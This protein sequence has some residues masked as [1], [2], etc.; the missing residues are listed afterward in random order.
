MSDHADP[1][2]PGPLAPP[3]SAIQVASQKVAAIIEAA[4]TAAADLRAQTEA[5][6][7]DRIA[8]ADRAGALRVEAAEA[9]AAEIVAAAH[10]EAKGLVA[11]ARRLRGEA[12]AHKLIAFQEADEAATRT[13]QTAAA[14]G[15][16]AR[17]RAREDARVIVR[18]ARDAAAQVLREG[19]E[20]S[21]NLRDLGASLQRNA[22]RLLGDVKLA[23]SAL[24]ADLDQAAGPGT[25]SAAG[26]FVRDARQ[27]TTA[28]DA[29]PRRGDRSPRTSD[30][31]ELDVPEF[32]PR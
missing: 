1:F 3:A 15:D 25:G 13:L 6:A 10:A 32:I 14:E 11:D 2:L 27:P 16:A 9:E 22:G 29:A 30:A 26:P 7:R 12:D 28:G 5:R 17:A 24:T 20:L 8:E 23:H 31:D 19:N 21:G 18:E 4:E